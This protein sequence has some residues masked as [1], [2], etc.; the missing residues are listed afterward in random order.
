MTSLSQDTNIFFKIENLY[1]KYHNFQNFYYTLY[2][3]SFD[4]QSL[5]PFALRFIKLSDNFKEVCR[6]L[7][8]IKKLVN[9]RVRN[10]QKLGINEIKVL[11][12]YK[13]IKQ[14]MDKNNLYSLILSK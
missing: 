9:N 12:K 4:N 2:I 1:L 8:V 7:D 13:D 5:R 10:I 6:L 14:L 11:L 3:E